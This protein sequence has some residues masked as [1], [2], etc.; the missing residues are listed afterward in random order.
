MKALQDPASTTSHHPLLIGPT[1]INDL[2]ALHHKINY[3]SLVPPPGSPLH[4]VKVG[5]Y[6]LTFVKYMTI[7]GIPFCPDSRFGAGYR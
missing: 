7:I 3:L 5:V 1:R 6:Y 4:V 2:A